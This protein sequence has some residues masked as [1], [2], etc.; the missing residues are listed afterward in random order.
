M[1]SKESI[2]GELRLG[3]KLPKCGS[4]WLINVKFLSFFVERAEKGRNSDMRR[5][6]TNKKDA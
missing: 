6:I 5:D 1:T 4:F 3:G 2:C